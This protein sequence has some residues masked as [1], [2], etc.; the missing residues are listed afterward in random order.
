MDKTILALT[1]DVVSSLILLYGH[2]SEKKFLVVL[3]QVW[4]G[5]K[6]IIRLENYT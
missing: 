4:H 3:E 6:L 2:I 5:F 1:K